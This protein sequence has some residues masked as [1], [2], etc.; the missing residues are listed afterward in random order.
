ML[1]TATM[2]ARNAPCLLQSQLN[3]KIAAVKQISILEGGD[4]CIS[5]PTYKVLNKHRFLL[6]RAEEGY[7]RSRASSSMSETER[8]RRSTYGDANE[9]DNVSVWDSNAEGIRGSWRARKT[10]SFG[11]R[12]VEESTD[13]NGSARE[14]SWQWW[15]S[16]PDDDDYE[17]DTDDDEDEESWFNLDNFD[18]LTAISMLRWMVPA[19]A[20]I[21]PWLFGGPMFLM[22]AFAFFPLVQKLLGLFVPSAWKAALEGRNASSKTRRREGKRR[23]FWSQ[24]KYDSF[25]DSREESD[26]FSSDVEDWETSFVRSSIDRESMSKLG[27]W[28][29]KNDIDV[30]I[31]KKGRPGKRKVALERRR[32]RREVPLFLRLLV[33]LFPFLRS[34][35]GFL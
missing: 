20:L 24:R 4:L 29:E 18:V 15:R 26:F 10:S 5:P 23:G 30:P 35:G 11:S 31:Q 1:P 21:L 33:A 12:P 6:V 9:P 19:A 34:W 14:D 13:A 7:G 17:G 25:M 2:E 8:G 32:S 16:G 22:M 28:G 27:G 3:I